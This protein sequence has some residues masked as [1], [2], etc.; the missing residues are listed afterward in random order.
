M[1]ER[2]PAD[3]DRVDRSRLVAV[4]LSVVILIVMAG[5][6]IFM[7]YGGANPISMPADRGP[8]RPPRPGSERSCLVKSTPLGAK[9]FEVTGDGPVALGV[10]PTEIEQGDYTIRVEL[11]HHVPV[12]LKVGIHDGACEL[13][14]KL[15]LLEE[16][17]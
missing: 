4:A 3:E 16:T 8:T 11:E 10:T 14:R 17:P 7:T 12:E 5:V 15:L 6:H 1:S 9:I 2:P 13:H